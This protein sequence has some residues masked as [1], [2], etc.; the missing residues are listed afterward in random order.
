M[1][2]RDIIKK[3]ILVIGANG[4][5]GQRLIAFYQSRENI[6][7]L[8]SSL[9]AEPYFSEV[10]Y[11]PCDIT[12]REDVKKVIFDFYPDVVINSAGITNVDLCE[13]EK[14]TAW[15]V[16][17][18]GVE[19]LADACRSIDA[20][21]IHVSSDYVFNGFNGPYNENAK[22]DPLGYYGRTKLASE[23]ALKLSAITYS[24]IRTNV[25]YGIANSRPDFVRW[26]VNSLSEK[27]Q[28][29][30][31]QDQI[32]NPT[33][34]EDLVCAINKMVEL[35]KFGLYNIGGKDFLSRYEF[36]C[37]IAD[38]FNFDKNLITPITTEELKQAA[39]RPLKSGLITIKAETDLGYKPHSIV[40]ALG[41]IKKQ[42]TL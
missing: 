35:D 42:I 15:K 14:E 16:N 7:L 23:N 30:V 22:V 12:S 9:E 25:L 40:D 17:V 10:T 26:V 19:Y 38:F 3:R 11:I 31:V 21:M 32:N 18:K 28:I 33:F 29:R 6:E 13:K 2:S 27:K 24:V 39:K 4:L 41:I 5:L 1:Y 20:K 8:G 36:A 34:V 37:I